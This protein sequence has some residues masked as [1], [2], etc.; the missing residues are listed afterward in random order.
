MRKPDLRKPSYWTL[1]QAEGW[2]PQIVERLKQGATVDCAGFLLRL[3]PDEVEA[4]E[5]RAAIIEYD[6]GLNR[7]DAEQLALE[8]LTCEKMA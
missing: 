8:L 7:T 4:V 6:A 5:E 1:K 2:G 3:N